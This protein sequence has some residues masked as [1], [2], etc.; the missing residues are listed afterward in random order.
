MNNAAR[1]CS[2]RSS[3]VAY[4]ARRLDAGEVGWVLTNSKV[5][6]VDSKP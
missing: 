3:K 5:K 1:K 2:R 4:A 6:V